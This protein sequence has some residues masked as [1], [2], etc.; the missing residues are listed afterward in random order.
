MAQF[1]KSQL[2][3]ILMEF[4]DF[5]EALN[6]QLSICRK[7][8]LHIETVEFIPDNSELTLFLKIQMQQTIRNKNYL[9][10]II[11]ICSHTGLLGSLPQEM[12]LTSC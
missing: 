9:L 5:P 2:C 3:G 1:K 11:Q 12:K 8:I 6:Y 10:H 4:L 7:V